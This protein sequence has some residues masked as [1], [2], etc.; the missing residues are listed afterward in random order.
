L[1]A[2]DWLSKVH[3]LTFSDLAGQVSKEL[4]GIIRDSIIAADYRNKYEIGK[5]PGFS[6][7]PELSQCAG[8]AVIFH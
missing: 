6:A 1:K 7:K 3:L 4:K 5:I 8:F 2:V